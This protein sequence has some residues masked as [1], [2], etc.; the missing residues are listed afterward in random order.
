MWFTCSEIYSP[1]QI[2]ELRNL[3][4]LKLFFYAIQVDSLHFCSS[5]LNASPVLHKF[6]IKVKMIT[7]DVNF[8]VVGFIVETFYNA[9]FHLALALTLTTVCIMHVHYITTFAL[10]STAYNSHVILYCCV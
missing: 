2:S 4:Q 9:H 3:K 10:L 7:L 6:I 8:K 5:L 1:P